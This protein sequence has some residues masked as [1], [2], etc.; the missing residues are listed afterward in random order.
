MT[1]IASTKPRA[2]T[3]PANPQN[4]SIVQRAFSFQ[5]LL[6]VLLVAGTCFG[7]YLNIDES[8]PHSTPTSNIVFEGDTWWHVVVGNHILSTGR[9]PTAD[10]YSFTVHGAPWI[11][12]EWLGEVVMALASRLA[13]LEGLMG[14]LLIMSGAFVLL[15]YIYAYQRCR[16]AMASFCACA[17]LLPLATFFFSLRPQMFGYAFLLVTLIALEK[18]RHGRP[19]M[20]WFLPALFLVWVNTHGNFIIGLFVIGLYWAAGLKGFQFK[21][22]RAVEWNPKQRTQLELI[23]LLSLLASVITPYGTRLVAYPLEMIVHQSS[24]VKTNTEWLPIHAGSVQGVLFFGLLALFAFYLVMDRPVLRLEEVALLLFGACETLAHVRFALVFV[25]VFAPLLATAI[26]KWLPAGKKTRENSLA[27]A[28]LMCIVIVLLVGFFPSSKQINRA[29]AHNFP[30]AA[31]A[32]LSHNQV[33]GPMFNEL[34]WGGYLTWSLSPKHQ[35]FI[36]GREDIYDYAGVLADYLRI[37]DGGQR[38]I[39]LLRKYHIRS[40]LLSP[41]TPLATFLA[42][43][44]NWE[45]GYSD[46]SSIIFVKTG[47]MQRARQKRPTMANIGLKD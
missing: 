4:R 31:A 2:S 21:F 17:A 26:S 30:A 7:R 27:N 6:G 33:P 36:D 10:P 5:V 44:P 13:G 12:Y 19:I 1:E 28:A 41:S 22:V 39:F 45:K 14:L 40:C 11:A 29:I 46:P 16:N 20:L 8:L 32:F 34:T 24:I 3:T 47:A 35:V 23:S 25:P 15:L 42:S 37:R 43:L 38:A 9:W 18:F